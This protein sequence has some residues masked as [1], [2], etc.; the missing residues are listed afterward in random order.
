LIHGYAYE[1]DREQSLYVVS[2]VLYFVF[3]SQVDQL[4]YSTEVRSTYENAD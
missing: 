2:W 4:S 1:F 3:T